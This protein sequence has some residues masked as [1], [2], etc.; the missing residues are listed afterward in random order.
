MAYRLSCPC[1]EL[2]YGRTEEEMVEV[3]A[4]HARDVHSREYTAAEIMFM[5][6]SVP[7]SFLPDD[8]RGNPSSDPHERTSP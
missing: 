6:I 5:A 8:L 4:A 7:D 1:T 3:A 2:L